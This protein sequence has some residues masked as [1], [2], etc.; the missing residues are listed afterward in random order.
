MFQARI[1]VCQEGYES[2][3]RGACKMRNGD[4]KWMKR[5]MWLSTTIPESGLI[6][7]NK[8]KLL[9]RT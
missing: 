8:L 9:I 2:C 5:S 1:I 4:L 7:Q 3:T 6:S